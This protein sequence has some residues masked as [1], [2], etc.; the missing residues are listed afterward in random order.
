MGLS[1][2][3]GRVFFLYGPGENLNRLIPSVIGSL[4]QGKAAACTDCNQ[5]RDFLYIE[6]VADALVSLTDSDV[7]GVVNVGSG[8]PIQL[9]DLVSEIG[10]I[11]DAE[12]HIQFGAIP[13]AKGEPD[14]LRAHTGRLNNE[15]HWYPS[16]SLQ[17]GL[18]KTIDW[19]RSKKQ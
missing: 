19:V 9:K 1:S 18:L 4:L 14:I 2:A 10:K 12:D 7:Q 13:R 17:D 5:I 16:H 6:D 8:K 11:L 3:T 15:L